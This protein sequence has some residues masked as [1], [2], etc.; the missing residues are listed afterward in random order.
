MTFKPNVQLG[1]KNLLLGVHTGNAHRGH[2]EVMMVKMCVD[3]DCNSYR[4]GDDDDDFD[5]NS[6]GIQ[7]HFQ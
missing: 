4:N 5:S 7:S 1:G 2:F 3:D 6:N